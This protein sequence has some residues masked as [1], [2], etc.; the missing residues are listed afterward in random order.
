ME[1]KL[2]LMKF[3]LYWIY[4]TY[5]PA[6]VGLRNSF[7]IGTDTVPFGSLTPTLNGDTHSFWIDSAS[8]KYDLP[9]FNVTYCELISLALMKE[10]WNNN[11]LR[12]HEDERSTNILTMSSKFCPNAQVPVGCFRQKVNLFFLGNQKS[13]FVI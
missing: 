11:K 10:C 9:A 7:E 2:L 5:I 6:R 4:I 3:R 12:S 8:M 13:W 1:W